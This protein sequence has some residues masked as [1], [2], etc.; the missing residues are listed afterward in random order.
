MT[1]FCSRFVDD[2]LC[3]EERVLWCWHRDSK[4][5]N[6]GQGLVGEGRIGGED[7]KGSKTPPYDTKMADT[8]HC[9]C[10]QIHR[11]YNT[12]LSPNVNYGVWGVVMC[13]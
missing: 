10:I 12:E 1:T 5:I 2:N 7:F 8:Y 13:H 3:E 9:K 4:K 11:M 6:G